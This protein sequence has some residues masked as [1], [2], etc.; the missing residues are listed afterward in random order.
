[1]MAERRIG[2]FKGRSWAQI[3]SKAEH[4]NPKTLNC[5][6]NNVFN[7]KTFFS[8]FAPYAEVTGL[9]SFFQV[10]GSCIVPLLL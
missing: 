4:L 1:M 8:V 2:L 6:S 10:Q 7:V 3:V 9:I 5:V